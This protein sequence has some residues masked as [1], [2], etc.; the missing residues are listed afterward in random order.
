MAPAPAEQTPVHD[1]AETIA[2]IWVRPVDA[3]AM[4]ARKEIELIFP[5]I[6]TLQAIVRF[7]SAG[8]LL[9]AAARMGAVPSVLPRVVV[10]GRGLRIL[11]PGDPGYDEAVLT[12]PPTAEMFDAAT[13]AA[14]RA[15]AGPAEAD[16]G[17]GTPSD[18]PPGA[19]A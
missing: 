7:S 13:R 15:A 16:P 14:S 6:K 1:A 18:A 12:E 19:G 8:E 11:L 10:D 9:D 17:D 5:T 2:D 3:L 4:Y